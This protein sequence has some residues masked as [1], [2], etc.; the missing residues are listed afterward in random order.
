MADAA[1]E[2]DLED[3]WA[4]TFERWSLEQAEHYVG[5]LALGVGA[6][7]AARVEKATESCG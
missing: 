3:I 6:S 4:H 5:E 7:R 2:A 1:G